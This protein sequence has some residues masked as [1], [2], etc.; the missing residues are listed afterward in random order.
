MVIENI[1]I[2]VDDDELN[3]F[4]TSSMI[5]HM[6]NE[7]FKINIRVISFEYPI[8]AWNYVQ[9]NFEIQNIIGVITDH[10]MPKMTGEELAENISSLGI[11]VVIYSGNKCLVEKKQYSY[12]Y[13]PTTLIDLKQIIEND[14]FSKHKECVHC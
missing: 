11:P 10:D 13:K 12:I 5:E 6:S 9:N 8:D 14:F 2:V 4:C 1:I 7:M 3:L